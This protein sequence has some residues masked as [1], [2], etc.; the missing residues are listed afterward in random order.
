MPITGSLETFSLPELFQI[1]ESGGKTGRLSFKPGLKKA[2]VSRKKTW[3]L[4]FKK[5]HFIG[6]TNPLKDQSLTDK[7]L[8]HE[9]VET[10]SLVR[11][12]YSCP[13]KKDLGSYLQEQS[14]LNSSQ[15]DLLFNIQL[16]ESIKLFDVESGRFK[17]EDLNNISKTVGD[18][19]TFPWKEMTGRQKKATELSLE[20][21]RSVSNWSRFAEDMPLAECGLQRLVDSHNLKL[22]F[23]ESYLWNMAD[24][25]IS[26]KKIAHNQAIDLE[27]I[28]QTALSMIFAGLVEEVPVQ[29]AAFNVETST[30]FR[31]KEV[32]AGGPNFGTKART[33]SKVSHSLIENLVGFLRNNF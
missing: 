4:W 18:G 15:I 17:F 20:A 16:D 2:D 12:K 24:L 3:K 28:Q 19:E 5:G 26:L 33:K 32:L 11:A 25:S 21:M 30:K 29:N 6:I 1:I 10:K 14:I 7:I 23:L 9:W 8:A 13:D 22:N 27:V 31:Q